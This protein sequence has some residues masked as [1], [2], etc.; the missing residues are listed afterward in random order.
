MRVALVAGSAPGHAFP[1]AALALALR[2]AGADVHVVT[3]AEWLPALARDGIPG[4]PLPALAPD[5]RDGDLGFALYGRGAQMAPPLARSV[6]RFAPDLVVAD[7]I[8]LF[9]GFAAGLLGVP[10]V[11]LVPHPL[12]DISRALPAPGTGFAPG[13]GPVAAARDAL[14]RRLAA[15]DRARG[16][17]ALADARRSLGLPEQGPPLLRLIATLPALEPRRPDWPATARVV[18]PLPWDPATAELAPPPGTGPLVVV[19]PSTGIT[20]AVDLLGSAVAGLSGTGV[21]LAATVLDGTVLDGPG[22]GTGA[23]GSGP[24][25]T[26]SASSWATVGRG[27]QGPLL[28]R[29]AAVVTNGGHGIVCKALTRGIPLV[30]VPGGGDQH[31]NGQRVA[32]LGAGVALSARWLSP[33]AVRAAVLRVIE[34]PAYA[35]AARRAG[36]TGRGLGPAYAAALLLRDPARRPRPAPPVPGFP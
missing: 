19:A 20:G 22:P 14:L 36:A 7:T 27:R 21:R 9:G 32:R 24:P 26:S 25:L 13:G 18:G 29:A 15:R 4:S 33:A 31:E 3:G 17:A 34:R 23:T 8:S 35:A 5:P 6:E 10:W 16:S 11:E 28:D 12:S 30:I 2:A 1:V